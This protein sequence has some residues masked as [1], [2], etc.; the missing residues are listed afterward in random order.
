MSSSS[1]L[2]IFLSGVA[3]GFMNVTAGGGS[4]I[5]LPLL[6]LLGGLPA[7]A[8]NGTNRVA[9]LAQNL[10]AIRRF[11]ASGYRD[12][13]RGLGLAVSAVAGAVLGSVLAQDIPE[14]TFRLVLGGIMVPALLPVLRKPAVAKQPEVVEELR[15]P[16]LQIPV[17]FLIGAF[18]GFIQAGTG[19]LIIA[20]LSTL[21]GLSLVRT[22][23]L[24]LVII[25]AY[26]LPSI[27][28]FLVNGNVRWLPALILTGGCSLGGWLGAAFAITKGDR[29]I[30]YV[31]IG[32]VLG[33][34][35]KLIGLY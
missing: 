10:I 11:R 28:V 32:S 13:R 30:R 9:I 15:H 17:F 16:R 4:F 21:G 7:A 31:L 19:Y 25:A 26:I 1:A 18:G 3:A 35:G 23:S 20:A 5:T 27:L 12:I 6:I 24:K 34:A 14:G 8:A 2:L 33:L 22:N 29:W